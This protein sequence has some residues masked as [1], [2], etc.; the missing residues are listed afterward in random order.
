[1]AVCKIYIGRLASSAIFQPIH[2]EISM[3]LNSLKLLKKII[4]TG[5][6][7]SQKE[8]CAL[9]ANGSMTRSIAL[10]GNFPLENYV[11]RQQARPFP[12]SLMS[13]IW[14]RNIKPFIRFNL[15]N[16]FKLEICRKKLPASDWALG[17]LAVGYGVVPMKNSPLQL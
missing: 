9:F 4:L 17:Q 8:T 2:W 16:T 3:P 1:M 13:V 6:K 10:A 5:K 7:K 11:K 14:T 15:W 12:K